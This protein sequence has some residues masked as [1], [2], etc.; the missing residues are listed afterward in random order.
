MHILCCVLHAS[1]QYQV[2]ELPLWD[3]LDV[4]FGLFCTR[5]EAKYQANELLLRDPPDG[6]F[7][8]CF[9]LGQSQVHELLPW[10]RSDAC[11]VLSLYAFRQSQVHELRLWYRPAACFALCFACIESMSG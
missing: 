4:C 10:D 11:C 7:M 3:R 2:K 8:L 6:H 5:I 9:I 1:R